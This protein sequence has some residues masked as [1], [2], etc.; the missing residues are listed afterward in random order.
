M[1][2]PP[3]LICMILYY[4][5]IRTIFHI[6]TLSKKIYSVITG[7]YIWSLKYGLT[8]NRINK[9]YQFSG[10]IRKSLES[11]IKI[12]NGKSYAN[13]IT[14]RERNSD[15]FTNI[16]DVSNIVT[17]YTSADKNIYS[18][19]VRK[20]FLRSPLFDH[21]EI[22]VGTEKILM[23]TTGRNR[24][25]ELTIYAYN[26]ENDMIYKK[27]FP[28]SEEHIKYFYLEMNQCSIVLLCH[29]DNNDLYIEIYD[30]DRE[31]SICNKSIKF[32]SSIYDAIIYY[33][34][35]VLTAYKTAI[36][37]N[38]LHIEVLDL[39]NNEKKIF[40]IIFRTLNVNLIVIFLLMEFISI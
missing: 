21:S 13:H 38:L 35:I 4:L 20:G 15:S 24:H 39:K 33:P 40:R 27:K 32:D 10:M 36:S 2:L 9:I 25:N 19:Y 12:Y 11:P 30:T 7:G 17:K 26:M 29:M 16:F 1:E 23:F 31:E 6:G 28:T 5:D 34:Y 14:D 22:Y 18:S 8:F 37:L 3:E